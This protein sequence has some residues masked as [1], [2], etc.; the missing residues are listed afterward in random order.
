M[1]PKLR[2]DEGDIVVLRPLAHT[3]EKDLEK[4]S[5]ALQFP[6]IPC[7]LCGSQENL[8]RVVV[9]QMLEGWEAQH[10][11]RKSV[12]AKALTNVRPSHL[13]DPELFDFADLSTPR[14]PARA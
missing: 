2:N 6:I 12:I 14:P 10:K 3:L 1:S 5:Q 7:N 8:Q 4:F 13:L 11:G 9:R